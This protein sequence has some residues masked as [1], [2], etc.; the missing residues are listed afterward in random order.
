MSQKVDLRIAGIVALALAFLGPA[1]AADAAPAAVIENFH[2]TL[3]EVMKEGKSLGIKGRYQRLAPEID[4][5]FH[6]EAIIQIAVGSS[7]KTA[8]EAQKKDLTA[9]FRKFS[10]S[11]Y[12]HQFKSHSGQSFVTVGEKPGPQES[13]LVDTRLVRVNDDPVDLTY[14]MKN[15]QG[16]WAI[17]DVVVEKGISQLA[18]QVSEYRRTLK[19][20]GVEGLTRSLND[21][22]AELIGE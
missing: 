12:A 5:A 2:G 14:V 4:Q 13:Q 21:K 11:T 20:D 15:L 6:L 10:I 19:T 18:R 8:T 1:A 3:I 16:R 7:W 17:V 22:A 9:A